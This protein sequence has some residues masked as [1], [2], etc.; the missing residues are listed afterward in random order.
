MPHIAGASEAAV[1]IVRATS[2]GVSVALRPPDPS[3][4]PWAHA[5]RCPARPLSRFDSSS[6]TRGIVRAIT[7]TCREEVRE[8][9]RLL[10]HEIGAIRLETSDSILVEQAGEDRH[11]RRDRGRA[12]VTQH[13]VPIAVGQAHVEDDPVGRW[14]KLGDTAGNRP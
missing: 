8:L 5:L 13:I 12:E 9:D 3:T 4:R 2:I 11:A 14:L 1:A 7:L 10:K 6:A